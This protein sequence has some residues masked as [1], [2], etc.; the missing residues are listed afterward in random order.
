M[1]TY[2]VTY[3][4]RIDEE[5]T[6]FQLDMDAST[7][8]P[9]D[10]KIPDPLPDWARLEHH[11]CP[12]CPLTPVESPHCPLATRLVG[13]IEPLGDFRSHRVVD[14]E[15]DVPGRSLKQQAPLQQCLGSLMGLLIASSGC[16]HTRFLRP[17][18]RYHQPLSTPDETIYRATAMYC[19]AQLFRQR[20]GL[21]TDFDLEKLN[22][23]F[24]QLQTVN[25]SV[26]DRLRS[27]CKDDSAI[28]AVV[29]LDSS[30][31]LLPLTSDRS[32]ANIQALFEDFLED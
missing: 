10:D 11:Q 23:R 13:V 32:L 1:P 30:A 19:M 14:L 25:A 16:P 5:T 8:M 27:I 18:A 21:T 15:V 7:L 3:K 4:I 17:M 31:K 22:D 29:L 20:K 24:E 6:T 12:N 9:L 26:A 2:S 28:N